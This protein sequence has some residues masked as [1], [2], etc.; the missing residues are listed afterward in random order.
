MPGRNNTP[1]PIP[2]PGYGRQ[3]KKIPPREAERNVPPPARGRR[4]SSSADVPAPADDPGVF[5]VAMSAAEAA[6]HLGVTE[7]AMGAMRYRGDG[8]AFIRYGRAVR[9]LPED[10]RSWWMSN[11]VEPDDPNTR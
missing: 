2:A 11:R 10:I 7:A 5:P 9:Y 8:P 6:H 3:G 4:R 1:G